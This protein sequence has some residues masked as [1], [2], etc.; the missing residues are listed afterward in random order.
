MYELVIRNG[1]VY[2]SRSRSF[3][4]QDVGIRGEMIAGLGQL[5]EGGKTEI[6][7]SGCIVSPGLIDMHCHIYPRFPW[8]SDSLPAIHPDV[9]LPASGV[10]T[11]VDAGTCGLDDF[12]AFKESVIERSSIRIFAFLNIAKGGM[13]HL[14][15][16]Q[17]PKD[18][19]AETVGNVAGTQECI[20]GIKTAHYTADG[21]FDTAHGPWKSV[22]AALEAAEIAGKPVMADVRPAEPERTFQGLLERLRPGDIHTHIYAKHFSVLD[23][24]GQV[25]DFV[26]VA[27][28]RG[29][30]FDLGHGEG[31]FVFEHA[32][33]AYEKG[34]Y[35]DTISTDLY[36]DNVNG[37]AFGLLSVMNKYL[38][39][40]MPLSE[41]LYRVTARPAEVISRRDLGVIQE[42]GPADIAILRLEEG[43]CSF[44]DCDY[45]RIDGKEKLT[46]FMTI[47]G[48]KI[49]YNPEAADLPLW[50]GDRR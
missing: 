9:H 24:N 14:S 16:E 43:R 44:P 47:K 49:I 33:P 6:D 13:V 37:P 42:G 17:N 19:L 20:V 29:I 30:I 27:R 32:C 4:G 15:S 7:A 31:S 12:F 5:G 23:E 35:P 10:T 22:D 46:C 25:R 18:F 28:E 1:L 48:G 11:A 39:I 36:K 26:R 2:N 41:V 21:N 38:A 3:E 40:G 45:R 34:F 8:A 50:S